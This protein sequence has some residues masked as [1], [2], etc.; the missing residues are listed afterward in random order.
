MRDLCLGYELHVGYTEEE[1]K[2]RDGSHWAR[3]QQKEC[4]CDANHAE[5]SHARRNRGGEG[6]GKFYGC[7]PPVPL[8]PMITVYSSPRSGCAT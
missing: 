7:P 8:P 6:K 5:L 3:W 4:E 2:S 1:Q